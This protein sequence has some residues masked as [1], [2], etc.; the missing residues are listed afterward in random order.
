MT[1]ELAEN[2]KIA[3]AYRRAAGRFIARKSAEGKTYKWKDGDEYYKW[4]VSGG[5]KDTNEDQY[6]LYG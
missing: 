6:E 5:S 3:N 1:R 2:P 4:W